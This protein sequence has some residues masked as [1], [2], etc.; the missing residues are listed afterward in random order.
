MTK[1][2]QKSLKPLVVFSNN[3]SWIKLVT[4]EKF[5]LKTSTCEFVV[6]FFAVC[7]EKLLDATWVELFESVRIK[8]EVYF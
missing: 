6:V 7:W 8:L 3:S 5:L 1:F 2:L 4:N